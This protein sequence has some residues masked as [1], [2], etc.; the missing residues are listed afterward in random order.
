MSE[1]PLTFP[2]AATGGTC[3]QGSQ[4]LIPPCTANAFTTYV[5]ITIR[6]REDTIRLASPT[7]P[8]LDKGK[9][10]MKL[11]ISENN[12]DSDDDDAAVI[13]Y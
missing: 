1:T 12:S 7:C 4:L 11:G 2:I 6:E 3:S 8:L 5:D 13:L 10:I 9:R